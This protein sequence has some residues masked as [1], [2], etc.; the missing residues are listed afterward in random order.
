MRIALLFTLALLPAEDA[1][2]IMAK[3]AANMESG[4]EARRNY[5]YQQKVFARLLRTD[6]QVARQERRVYSAVPGK[7]RTAKEL[8]SLDGEYHKNKNEVIRYTGPEFEK[9]GVDVDGALVESLMRD[10]VENKKSR[11][12]IPHSLF[13]FRV[14]DLP[15]YQ[16]QWLGEGQHQGRRVLR[17]GFSPNKKTKCKNDEH[18]DCPMPW[19]GE[20]LIDAEEYQP[21]R[22]ATDLDFKMP[23]GVR[24]FLGTNLRQTGFSV[25]YTRVAENV[26]FPFTYGSEFRLDVL[27]GYKRVVT[28]ALDSSD[29]KRTETGT[30]IRYEGVEPPATLQ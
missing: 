22:I 28:L 20:A 9:G 25:T 5:V 29:F 11:D 21:V 18:S 24:F 10:F 26:W 2:S 1:Q 3:A 19:K 7:D 30:T 8:V 27:F 17:I 15:Y 4:A 16:F 23:W 12:G 13:P 6:G 14:A